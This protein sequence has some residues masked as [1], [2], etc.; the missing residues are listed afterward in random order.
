[1]AQCLFTGKLVCVKSNEFESS[2][3]I[4]DKIVIAF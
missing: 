4:N 1:L 3:S 2:E